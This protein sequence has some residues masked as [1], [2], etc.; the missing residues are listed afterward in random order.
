MTLNMRRHGLV[1]TTCRMYN[2]NPGSCN[3]SFDCSLTY[4]CHSV[5]VNGTEA[6]KWDADTWGPL[7]DLAKNHP[8][9]GVHFQGM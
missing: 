9:A 6:A 3:E 7:A 5:S 4:S 8:E 1:P 2:N